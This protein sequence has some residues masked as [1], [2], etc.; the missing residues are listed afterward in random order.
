MEATD[1]LSYLV[2]ETNFYAKQQF[3]AYKSV[4]A[5]NFMVSGFIASVQGCVVHENYI[6]TGKMKQS[7]QMND[8]L[9]LIWVIGDKDGTVNSAHCLGCK[10]GMVESCSHVASVLFY[11]ETWTRIFAKL[12]CTHVKCTWPFPSYVKEVRFARVRDIDFSSARELKTDL[13]AKIDSISERSE[14]C[15]TSHGSNL[16]TIKVP[17]LSEMFNLC[18]QLNKGKVKPVALSLIAPYS[19]QFVLKSR[20]ILTIS[21]LFD[22]ENM[23]LSYPDLLTKCFNV[24]ITLTSEEISQ[25]EKDTQNQAQGSGFFTHWAGRIGGSLSGAVYHTNVNPA[26][27]SQSLIKS[28][29]LSTF[30]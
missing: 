19:D 18:R 25:I 14:V 22:P 11:I 27:S 9:I 20:Q 8:P 15:V 30:I 3:K 5:Y 1:L 2:L 12:S 28:N 23:S 29:V 13:D 7:Q 24:E 21:D 26:Q 6:V 4:E 17:T 16:R 10:A